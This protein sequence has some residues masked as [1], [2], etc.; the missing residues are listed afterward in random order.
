[1]ENCFQHGFHNKE[2]IEDDQ[3][4]E[5]NIRTLKDECHWYI[6]VSNNG[7]VFP[8]EKIRYI[9]EEYE[10]SRELFRSGTGSK[11]VGYG[12]NNTLRRL[13]IFYSGLE[14][15]RIHSTEELT[16]ICIGGPL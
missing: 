8:E 5:I 15:I 2:E 14:V 3:K 6:E 12:L 13:H 16:T 1:V 7:A 11:P 4:W 9:L 10:Q